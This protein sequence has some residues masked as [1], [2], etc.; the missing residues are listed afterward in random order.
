MPRP[1]NNI[2]RLDFDSRMTICGMIAD[3]ATYDEIRAAVKSD[4][5][6]HNSSLRAY[7]QSAEYKE[8]L[9]AKRQSN[10]RFVAKRIDAFAVT[11]SHGVDSVIKLSEA[12]L[13]EQLQD[14]IESGAAEIADMTKAAAIINNLK[15]SKAET[16]VL[17]LQAENEKLKQ[18]LAEQKAAYE[19]T[20]AALSAEKQKSTGGLSEEALER[21]EEAAGLL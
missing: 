6:L 10:R 8:A 17:K 7:Q 18:Q 5:Q 2:A 3:G 1:R 11:Q 20:I 13:I 19:A 9:A 12:A 14:Y 21:I 15:Q 16:R 4:K